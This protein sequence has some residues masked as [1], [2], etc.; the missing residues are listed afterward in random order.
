M[1]NIGV[2]IHVPFCLRKCPYCDFYSVGSTDMMDDYI[3]SLC[4]DI[5]E[6]KD[7]LSSRCADTV[8]FGGGTPSLMSERHLDDILTAL[9][10]T[11]SLSA[12]AE[13]T[14][15]VNPATASLEK[16]QG[17]HSAGVDRLSI[18][19][20]SGDDEE[21][22]LLG[23]LHKH[24]DTVQTVSNAFKSGID[25]ISLDLMY[26]LPNQR[27]ETWL[28][29][30]GKAVKLGAKH[31]SLYALTLSE[32]CPMSKMKYTF[33]EDEVQLKM[34]TDALAYLSS[35]GYNQ[36]EIS[37]CAL[38]GSHSRH[39]MKYWR[40]D[41]YIGFGPSAHSMIDG[42]R[43]YVSGSVRDHISGKSM[44]TVDEVLTDEETVREKIMLSLRLSEGLR[45]DSL[46]ELCRD[47]D[48]YNTL[49]SSLISRGRKYTEGGYVSVSETGIS[50][51][52]LGFFVSNTIISDLM[53]A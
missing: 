26:A 14:L 42:R 45:F 5:R 52:Q 53:D 27:E 3:K 4:R 29:S 31:I 46:K 7:I 48:E 8:Y 34:Y 11:V 38:P 6:K 49:K 39:N 13:I 20:Q 41:D 40:L 43:Y 23:R 16:L 9:G 19:M 10:K 35:E 22:S 37:N 32:E 36:Y 2:Y 1:N 12:D 33:P 47:A 30:V 28:S 17:Y 51:T 44:E 25:N 15:E 21:L 50:L 18:G 24:S